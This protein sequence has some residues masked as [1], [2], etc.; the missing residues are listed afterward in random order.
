M[1]AT[2]TLFQLKSGRTSAPRL[3]QA[4]QTNRGSRSDKPYLIRPAIGAEGNA[5]AAMV[6]AILIR[7]K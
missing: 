3:P 5:M 7:E 4:L 1:A 6:V 2:G